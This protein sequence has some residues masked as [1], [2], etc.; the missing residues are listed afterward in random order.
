MYACDLSSSEG[1]EGR[2][3]CAASLHQEVCANI[4]REMCEKIHRSTHTHINVSIY[5]TV[6]LDTVC[7][8]GYLGEVVRGIRH[9]LEPS[10]QHS[11]VLT[12][13]DGLGRELNGLEPGRAHA[14]DGVTRHS[15]RQA[16]LDDS[17]ASRGLTYASTDNVTCVHMQNASEVYYVCACTCA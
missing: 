10:G 13:H 2:P 1:Q 6:V 16:G 7:H 12:D 17:L 14:V 5:T 9:A 8:C 3:I 15:L 4:H 11:L